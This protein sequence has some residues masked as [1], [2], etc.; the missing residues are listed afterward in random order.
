MIGLG[1]VC[2]G[3]AERYLGRLAGVIGRRA[4]AERH[5]EHALEAN[6]RLKAYVCLAHTQVDY[7]ELLGDDPHA[8][9][10]LDAATRTS[11]ELGL[12]LVAA[13]AR[14]LQK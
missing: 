11:R 2:L 1:A 12:P 8:G 5:F 3:S 13:R 9:T 7:A 10:L 14:L 4:E 6:A